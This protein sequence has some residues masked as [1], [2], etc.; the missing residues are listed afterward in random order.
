MSFSESIKVE[1]RQ[2]A[3][4]QCCRCR[5]MGVEVHHILPAEHGGSDIIDNAA[6]L[7]P[8]CHTDFGDNPKKRK[9]IKEMRN[10]W[11]D[12][13]ENMFGTNDSSEFL[14]EIS[15]SLETLKRGQS[16]ISD[17]KNLLQTYTEHTIGSMT[18]ETAVGAAT[19]IVTATT[20]ANNVHANF[21]CKKC[22]MRIGL[23]VG[24]NVCPECKEPI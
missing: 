11:Y 24:S 17:L 10:W 5:S 20:I 2:K 1:V 3:A 15:G 8:N 4:Y 14:K 6:P 12:K 16:D 7:C 22:G 19:E 9:I 18:N 13:V 23:L 21:H